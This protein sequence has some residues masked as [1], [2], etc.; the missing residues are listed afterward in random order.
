VNNGTGRIDPHDASTS[1]TA[2]NPSAATAT[3]RC[4]RR[5]GHSIGNSSGLVDRGSPSNPTLAAMPAAAAALI[6]T[7]STAG[8]ISYCS[9]T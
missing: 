3:A 2:A 8:T 1:T 5:I 7:R 4:D 9:V 6:P